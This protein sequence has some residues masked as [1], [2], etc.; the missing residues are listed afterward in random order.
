MNIYRLNAGEGQV[1]NPQFVNHGFGTTI[2]DAREDPPRGE[3]DAD[4]TAAHAALVR[5]SREKRF[6][7]WIDAEGVLEPHAATNQMRFTVRGLELL[8]PSRLEAS[9]RSVSVL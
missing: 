9:L 3:E 4:G 5:A 8:L 2:R 1:A 6:A 7:E